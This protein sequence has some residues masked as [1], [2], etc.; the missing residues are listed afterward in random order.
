MALDRHYAADPPGRQP[1]RCEVAFGLTYL[2]QQW[3]S[4]RRSSRSPA[5][6]ETLTGFALCVRQYQREAPGA[7][8]VFQLMDIARLLRASAR[9]PGHQLSGFVRRVGQ[10]YVRMDVVGLKSLSPISS[11]TDE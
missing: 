7:L 10:G 6:V 1:G 3:L 4:A 8:Q 5:L 2:R 9:Q 11:E